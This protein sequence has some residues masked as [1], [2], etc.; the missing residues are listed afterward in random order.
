MTNMYK[1][2][3]NIWLLI[4]AFFAMTAQSCNDDDDAG[5]PPNV[6]APREKQ[7]VWEGMNSWYLWQSDVPNLSNDVRTDASRYSALLNSA[8]DPEILFNNLRT[9][10]NTDRFSFIT[11][12][13]VALAN[14]FQGISTS[15]GYEFGLVRF[16]GSENIF[17]W[18]RYVLPGSPAENAGI[19]RGDLFTEVNG[20]TL[21][22]NNFRDLLFGLES[23]TLTLASIQGGAVTPTGETATMTSVEITENPVLLSKTIDLANGKKVG[24]LMY[25]SFVATF[26]S[27]LNAV[28]ADFKSQGVDDLVLDLRYN[29]G[30]SV[31]TSQYLSS[32]IYEGNPDLIFG[33]IDYNSK[34]TQF[35]SQIP[36]ANEVE[37]KNAD[38]QTITY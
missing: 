26:H 3:N 7:F 9:D 22:I 17:G 16:S 38:F 25:N 20:T 23:Y 21:N 6:E 37:L 13:Y 36:F 15:Y 32:M 18:V 35:N 27:E 30:G 8:S 4:I 5:G 28:F 19:V 34:H 10:G 14:S 2:N 1:I 33:N 11:D 12:D 24:Y 31:L 29:G